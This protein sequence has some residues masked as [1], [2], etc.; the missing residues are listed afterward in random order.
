MENQITNDD[1][2]NVTTNP[3]RSKQEIIQ[4]LHSKIGRDNNEMEPEETAS[5]TYQDA[6]PSAEQQETTVDETSDETDEVK[7]TEIPPVQENAEIQS[8]EQA[9]EEEPAGMTEEEME[10]EQVPAMETEEDETASEEEQDELMEEELT[11]G[12]S[13][14]ETP[15]DE[16][17][18]EETPEIESDNIEQE[19]EEEMTMNVKD[20]DIIAVHRTFDDWLQVSD[21]VDII[22]S[23]LFLKPC[24]GK[25]QLDEKETKA[26]ANLLTLKTYVNEALDEI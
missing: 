26:Y 17:I 24:D 25:V 9:P 12:I 16:A 3:E 2:G 18:S 8:D 7:E 22:I 5:E 4:E 10:E 21:S 23:N 11:E 20:P 15:E 13:E 6:E 1:Q 19:V 14:E